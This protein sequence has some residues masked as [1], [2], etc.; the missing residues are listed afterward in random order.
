MIKS[1]EEIKPEEGITVEILKHSATQGVTI[2]GYTVLPDSNYDQIIIK[3][4]T[5]DDGTGTTLTFNIKDILDFTATNNT[6]KCKVYDI[7][8]NA[9]LSIEKALFFNTATICGTPYSIFI[10]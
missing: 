7:A 10:D 3:R 4:P 8:S 6:I 9:S 1:Y 5:F 2:G